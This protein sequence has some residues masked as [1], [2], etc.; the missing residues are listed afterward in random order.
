MKTRVCPKYFVN[1]CLC[2]QLFTSNLP[3]TPSNLIL[4]TNFV[5]LRPLTLFQPKIRATKLQKARKF[6]LLD[7]YFPDLFTEVQNSYWKLFMFG[8]GPFLQ[9]Q[10]KFQPK[11]DCF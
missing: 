4:L 1:G 6:V 7:N 3:Q 10:S 9:R 5:T 2:K 11:Y 8:Q